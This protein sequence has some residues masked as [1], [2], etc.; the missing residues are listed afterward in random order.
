MITMDLS[1]H[2]DTVRRLSHEALACVPET[3]NQGR[4]VMEYDEKGLHYRLE[5][6]SDPTPAVATQQLAM[7][8]GELYVL[9]EMEG[10]RWSKCVID[11][12]KT[13]DESWKFEVKFKYPDS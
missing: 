12:T 3:W 1:R 5:N 13:P 10:Q 9:M 6:D 4:L 7:L 2:G 11:F 8:C